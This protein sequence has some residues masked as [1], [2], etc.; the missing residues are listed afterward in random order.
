MKRTLAAVLGPVAAAALAVAPAVAPHGTSVASKEQ[1]ILEFE[2]M[3]PV[4]EAFVGTANPIRGINGGGL[5]WEIETATGELTSAGHLEVEVS[6][7]V[8]LDGP[9]VP[10]DRQGINP[11]PTFQAVVSCLSAVDGSTV[12]LATDPVPATTSGDAKIEA[13]LD[14]PSTCVAPIVF[15]GPSPTAWFAATGIG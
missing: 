14:L 3:A 2:T 6:G 12:N 4:T 5:P 9:P 15:V 7:L 11:I 13:T 8:L 1:T 10:P